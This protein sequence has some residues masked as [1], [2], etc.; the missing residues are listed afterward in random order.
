MQSRATRP[1]APLIEVRPIVAAVFG[2]LA[3]IVVAAANGSNLP[4]LGG[5][6]GPAPGLVARWVDHVRRRNGAMSDRFGARSTFV[7]LPFGL[8]AL[9]LILSALFG[10][11][12]L[13]TPIADAMRGSGPAVSLDRAAIV[14]V[15]VIMAVK[16]CLAWLVYWP[17]R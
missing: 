5:G 7:G 10:W 15:G 17:R 16:W 3:V 1:R 13:L 4:V 9:A 11:G 14:G 2:I 8:A 6:S 12:L